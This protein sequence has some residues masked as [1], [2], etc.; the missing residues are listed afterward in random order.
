[1][2]RNALFRILAV[3]DKGWPDA[4]ARV[5]RTRRTRSCTATTLQFAGHRR[6]RS[7]L[8]D[9]SFSF[10]TLRIPHVIA[11]RC[12]RTLFVPAGDIVVNASLASRQ[13]Q[14]NKLLHRLSDSVTGSDPQRRWNMT[15]NAS[16]TRTQ[17]CHIPSL[18]PCRMIRRGRS[19]RQQSAHKS[20]RD[21]CLRMVYSVLNALAFAAPSTTARKAAS[22]VMNRV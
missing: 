19:L 20:R 12:A 2:T 7:R 18:D 15:G 8:A 21:L 16:Q 6:Q 11:A 5:G 9:F 4:R 22:S 10:N 1:M 17:H 3:L 14:L 13:K